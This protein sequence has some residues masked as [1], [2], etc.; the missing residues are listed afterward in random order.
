MPKSAP[1]ALCLHRAKNLFYVRICGRAYY[2]GAD[3]AQAR[4]AYFE[5]LA[6]THGGTTPPP[7]RASDVAVLEVFSHFVGWAE[8]YY[9]S[10]P[11]TWQAMKTGFAPFLEMYGE[12]P[13]A[14]F[15]PKALKA[16]RAGLIA[17]TFRGEGARPLARK[18]VNQRI[19]EIVRVFKFA[20][21]EE[22]IQPSVAQALAMVEPLRMGR[23]AARE[24]RP[25]KPVAWGDV[26]ATLPFLPRPVRGL[27]LLAW[28]TGARIG[29]LTPMRPRDID[30]SSAVWE[31][32]PPSHKNAW[33]GQDRVILI[34]PQGQEV[35][36]AA[37]MRARGGDPVFSPRDVYVE[38]SERATV[39]RRADQ[40]PNPR[41]TERT[42]NAEY[43]PNDITRAIA[44]AV[45][46]AN[47]E[48]ERSGLPT[49][50]RWTIHQVRHSFATR[51]RA[52]FG[53][54]EL[55]RAALG[56]AHTDATAIYAEADKALAATVAAK[57]G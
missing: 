45:E 21:S 6:E 4:R 10:N 48:R 46:Q 11:A 8:G 22:M 17:G 26:E 52:A 5:L 1:P 50:P 40:K 20:A 15:G 53:S 2:L 38:R 55:A 19:R 25:V 42:I 54:I 41:K 31:Y 34:G 44:R 35:L 51:C 29:E 24:P 12:M 28:H 36:R 14:S 39:H 33:R 56:H 47:A 13:A 27:V 57:I 7:T 30:R 32:R 23:S 16:Y 49:I 9:A 18:T 37:L 3:P 43:A